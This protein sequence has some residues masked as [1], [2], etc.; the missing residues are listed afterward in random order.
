[1]VGEQPKFDLATPMHIDV[2]FSEWVKWL[3]SKG[4]GL[5]KVLSNVLNIFSY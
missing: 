3:L 1:M 4:T 2:Y 5:R